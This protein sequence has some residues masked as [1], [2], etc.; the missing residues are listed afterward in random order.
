M[1]RKPKAAIDHFVFSQLI[2]DVHNALSVRHLYTAIDTLKDLLD[3]ADSL[4]CQP[5]MN[6]QLADLQATYDRMLHYMREGTDD[7]LRPALQ[8]RLTEQLFALMQDLRR[9]YDISLA[10]TAYATTAR[11]LWAGEGRQHFGHMLHLDYADDFEAQDR[12]FSCIWTSPQLTHQEE[13]QLKLLLIGQHPLVR[14]YVQSALILS[15]LHYF[16]PAKMRLLTDGA[17]VS[18]PAEQ[19]KSAVGIFFATHLHHASVSL[20]PTLHKQLR[21]IREEDVEIWTWLQHFLCLYL[22]TERFHELMEQHILPALIDFSK[23]KGKETKNDQ[24]IEL[25]EMLTDLDYDS[26]H[27][28]VEDV[29][30]MSNLAKEGMDTN[31]YAFA[32]L[33]KVPF[34]NHTGHWL[35]P[36][37]AKRFEQPLPFNLEK[38]PMCDSD[39]Y[40]LAIMFLHIDNQKQSQEM[41]STL[42]HAQQHA[43][44][45]AADTHRQHIQHTLQCFFRLFKSSDDYAPWLSLFKIESLLIHNPILGNELKDCDHFLKQTGTLLLSHSHYPEAEMHL[46]R[47]ARRNAK[48]ADLLMQLGECAQEQEQ[49]RKALSYYQQANQL[50]PKHMDTLRQ[51][52]QCLLELDRHEERLKYLLE[53]EEIDPESASIALQ[54]AFC[55]MELKRFDEALQRFYKLECTEQQVDLVLHHIPLCLMQLGRMQE[56]Q[57]YYG[58]LREYFPDDIQWE[59]EM[60]EGH[61]AWATGNIEQALDHYTQYAYLFSTLNPEE[62]DVLLPFINDSE[63]LHEMGFDNSQIALMHDMISRHI[64]DYAL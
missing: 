6:E 3:M 61:L 53:M 11:Q 31:F 39:R 15:L 12:L 45:S 54:T 52:E 35:A 48:N 58:R 5:E 57:K 63:L 30:E 10:N 62:P 22:E 36:F 19:A 41:Q 40:C 34:F 21:H 24:M 4:P 16:D 18:S 50:R 17:C 49:L 44:Q 60:N 59:D 9:A 28:L 27:M 8:Q 13:S 56:A 29:M 26:T 32:Q 23:K 20:F 1:K 46:S 64:Q 37:T 25:S 51:M 7:P 47:Y 55:L 38:L 43:R 2:T 42:Q 14:Q 33:K